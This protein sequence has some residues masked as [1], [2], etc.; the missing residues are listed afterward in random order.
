MQIL[1][2]FER[3][4]ISLIW[5]QKRISVYP[6]LGGYPRFR[7]FSVWSYTSNFVF[8][9]YGY[10][11]INLLSQLNAGLP[12]VLLLL[13]H[14]ELLGVVVRRACGRVQRRVGRTERVGTLELRAAQKRA[15]ATGVGRVLDC[16]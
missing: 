8:F 7:I 1:V 6:V 11:R 2:E 4:K 3:V 12:Q 9:R 15:A 5:S 14:L 16:A 10:T 13:E